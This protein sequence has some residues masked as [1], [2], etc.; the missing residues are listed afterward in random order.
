[1]NKTFKTKKGDIS[2]CLD[3]I[4]E[5]VDGQKL[6]KKERV[7]AM[8]SAEEALVKL[9]NATEEGRH[10]RIGISRR[11]G[12]TRLSMSS[13]GEEFNLY[14]ND[15]FEETTSAKI[16]LEDMSAGT[17]EEIR[18]ILLKNYEDKISYSHKNGANRIRISI[19]RS[20]YQMLILT[21]TGMILGI[22][23][24]LIFSMALPENA[25]I[26]LNEKILNSVTTVFMNAL[27]IVI[28]PV[29]FFSIATS[30]SGFGN[31]SDLG[32]VGVKTMGFYLMTS[33]IA[34]GIGVGG[35]MLFQTGDPELATHMTN[36]VGAIAS[37]MQSASTSI[38]DTLIGIVPNNLV[39]PFEEAN[40]LQIIFLAIFCGLAVSLLG[41]K[42]QMISVFFENCNELFLKITSIFMKVIPLA[43]FCS[44]C[45]MI[46]NTGVKSFISLLS[47]VG[48]FVV[49][50]LMLMSVYL[51]L[52]LLIC[53]VN[54]FR[55]LKK[56]FPTMV[57]VFSLCSSN[58]CIP[59]NM[60]AC[61]D[62]LGVHPR[63]YSLTI[64]LGATINMDGSCVSMVVITLSFCS[65]FGVPINLEMILPLLVTVLLLSIGAP[66]IPNAGLVVLA[67]LCV[68]VGVPVEAVSL[69][70]GIFPIVDMFATANNCLGD[71]VG[72]VCVAK[73]EGLV[74]MEVLNSN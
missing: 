44:M 69:V 4:H 28:A 60:N 51:V 11:F 45:S 47:I 43:T 58:A 68:Q 33:L 73:N 61:R 39:K 25:T 7:D 15:F 53:R 50:I 16:D 35:Y 23:F 65:I 27:K 9:D 52:L 26:W 12:Q 74:D 5:V 21:F 49:C 10:I 14:G 71:V 46:I 42:A 66:G 24:G 3:F 20:R 18:S 57:Q 19:A 32:R 22:L 41:K 38:L 17:E 55:L 54:P 63:V 48:V 34:L 70:M 6:D 2:G 62:A 64:P 72:T 30:I 8:I 67:I 36:D 59:L 31:M 1:M 13:H 56:Y 40:M 29:V 37:D